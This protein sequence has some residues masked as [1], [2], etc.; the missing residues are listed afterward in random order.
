MFLVTTIAFVVLFVT[1]TEIPVV[2]SLIVLSSAPAK[3]VAAIL[4]AVETAALI[5]VDNVASVAD[6][7]KE[8]LIAG[9]PTANLPV[10]V[11]SSLADTVIAPIV[12]S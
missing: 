2:S 8:M 7:V 5:A 3:N 10:I 9:A 6:A 4:D 11:K 12:P 1:A